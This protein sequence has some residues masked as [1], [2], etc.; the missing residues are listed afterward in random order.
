MTVN[1]SKISQ[2]GSGLDVEWNDGEKSSFNFLWLRDNC[3]SEIHKTA[4]E[5]TFNI[6]NISENIAPESFKISEDGKLEVK[7]NEDKH[8][9]YYEPSWL[10]KNCYTI[11]RKKAYVSPYV[12]WDKALNSQMPE[13]QIN[14]DVVMKNDEGLIKWLE[15]LHYYGIAIIKNAPTEKKS[16]LKILDKISHIRQTFF[17]TPFEVINIP[18]PNN[19][20]YT[21]DSLRN[22][23]DLPYFETPPGYQFLH[24][25]VNE[26][27]GGNS[28]AADGFKVAD[29]LKHNDK[30]TFNILKRI[31][32]KF[33]NKDYTQNKHRVFHAPAITLTKDGD[34]NDIR[35][36]MTYMGVIDCSSEDVEPFYKAHY[37][38]A[39]LIHSEK[40]N[41]KFRL[42][43]GDIFC[44]NNRRILHGRTEYNPNSGNRHLQGYYIDRDEI[45]SRLNYLKKIDTSLL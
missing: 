18:K 44:F 7:W 23:M 26:A 8:V 36:S 1:I 15:L 6:L 27:E 29:Y 12:L 35:F 19:S 32:I 11:K 30:E 5:R 3:P 13:I 2:N 24:C 10:R 28:S 22:H 20:A 37:K 40:F 33:V 38:F 41:I 9:S 45:I 4:R 42:E 43:S 34:Y 14:C 39:K 17:D 25:L 31:P 16:A 21:A